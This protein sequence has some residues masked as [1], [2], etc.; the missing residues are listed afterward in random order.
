MLGKF[1]NLFKPTKPIA[2][3]IG[4]QLGQTVDI[5]HGPLSGM[6]SGEIVVIGANNLYAVATEKHGWLYADED[7]LDFWNGAVK[8]E[9]DIIEVSA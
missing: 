9:C 3:Q 4:Y 6:V 1:I 5:W 7:E 2:Y 8:P